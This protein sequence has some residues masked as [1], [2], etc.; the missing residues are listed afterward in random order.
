MK[1]IIFIVW[2]GKVMNPIFTDTSANVLTDT[3]AKTPGTSLLTSNGNEWNAENTKDT[4]AEHTTN[5]Q[6]RPSRKKWNTINASFSP[7]L[8]AQILE[9]HSFLEKMKFNY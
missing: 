4:S 6:L 9:K 8:E 5:R 2:Q 3:L 7:S 1:H